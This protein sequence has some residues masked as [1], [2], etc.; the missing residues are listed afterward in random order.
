MHCGIYRLYGGSYEY[1]IR[2]C[3]GI[4]NAFELLH[5]RIDG[6]MTKMKGQN[7]FFRCI[8]N[9]IAYLADPMNTI[10]GNAIMSMANR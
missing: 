3:H 1:H 9:N 5:F 6:K 2:K 4:N 8:A 7:V 10:Q